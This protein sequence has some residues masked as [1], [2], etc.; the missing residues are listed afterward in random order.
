MQKASGVKIERRNRSRQSSPSTHRRHSSP[1]RPTSK[2]SEPK[3][4][5]SLAPPKRPRLSTGFCGSYETPFPP[6]QSRK[7]VDD[8]SHQQAEIEIFDMDD[9][10]AQPKIRPR[11]R[12]NPVLQSMSLLISITDLDRKCRND[13]PVH[14]MK[15]TTVSKVTM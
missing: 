9:C 12:S 1:S 10:Q 8:R 7:N 15:D 3:S 11:S 6:I 5:V 4:K 14:K 2:A 13:R